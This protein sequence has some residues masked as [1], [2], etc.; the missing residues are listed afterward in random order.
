[1]KKEIKDLGFFEVIMGGFLSVVGIILLILLIGGPIFTIAEYN[2]KEIYTGKITDKYNKRGEKIDTFYIVLDNKKV[3]ANTD[4]IFK[5]RF[6]SADVQAT[7]HVGE[8]VKVKTIGYRIPII[9]SYP[10]MYEIE[11]VKE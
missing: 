4:L 9:S 6:N 5:G 8:K 11:K 2:H 1:M 10:K 7:L 3:I